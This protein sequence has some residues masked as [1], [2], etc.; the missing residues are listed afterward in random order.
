MP[1]PFEKLTIG[2]DERSDLTAL[3]NLGVRRFFGGYLSPAWLER[4]ASQLSLNRR[5]RQRE[6]FVDLARLQSAIH[7]IHAR[8]G[9]LEL[10]LNAPYLNT[11][12]IPYA[13][14]SAALFNRLG[15][16]G[17]IVGSLS[18]LNQLHVQGQRGLVLSNL[19]GCYSTEAVRFFT[20]RFR[21][22]RVVLPRDLSHAEIARIV[23]SHPSVAFE[24][25]LFGDHCRL[26]EA[27]CFVEHGYD[28]VV[29]D[30]LCGYAAKNRRY[31][32]RAPPGFRRVLRDRTLSPL[33]REE[34]LGGVSHH[35]PDILNELDVALVEGNWSAAHGAVERFGRFNY[36]EQLADDRSTLCRAINLF[37]RLQWPRAEEVLQDLEAVF[38]SPPVA[39]GEAA[40]LKLDTATIEASVAYFARYPNIVA[41]K[42]P[43]RGR[44]ALRMLGGVDEDQTVIGLADF[45]ASLYQS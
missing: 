8:G 34:K 32:R 33:E 41:Y 29:R 9:T 16:D 30:D 1:L 35:L 21:P 37:R 18:L 11:E 2:I 7:T 20:Q 23:R 17:I 43:A 12:T 44:D 39:N 25:F 31:H 14:E 19:L 27:F 22:A 36:Q 10:A 26:S 40:Y 45:R 28:S 3:L 13:L 42:I 4:Y 38:A 24:V 6:Q 5:Y 15:V